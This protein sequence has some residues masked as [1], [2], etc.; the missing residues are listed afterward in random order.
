MWKRLLLPIRKLLFISG[1]KTYVF[2]LP[3]E[4][5]ILVN[6][7]RVLACFNS[8]FAVGQS[9]IIRIRPIELMFL[10][11]RISAFICIN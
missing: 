1:D 3:I 6:K 10:I 8:K 9:I 4:K 7:K 5:L 2:P 11:P